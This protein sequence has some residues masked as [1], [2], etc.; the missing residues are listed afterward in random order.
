MKVAQLFVGLLGFLSAQSIDDSIKLSLL[1]NV[2]IED[3][4]VKIKNADYFLVRESIKKSQVVKGLYS[5]K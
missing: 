2:H 4:T 5:C 1:K 3:D